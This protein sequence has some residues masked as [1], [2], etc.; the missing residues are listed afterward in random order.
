MQPTHSYNSDIVLYLLFCE[1]RNALVRRLDGAESKMIDLI[2][3]YGEK[4]AKMFEWG[5]QR[6]KEYALHILDY[7]IRT[8]STTVWTV[9]PEMKLSETLKNPLRMVKMELPFDPMTQNAIF[10]SK[11]ER[12][13]HA[14]EAKC[15]K[16]IRYWQDI[17]T[18]RLT[19]QSQNSITR[20][21]ASSL[22]KA[23]TAERSAA[24]DEDLHLFHNR[25][26]SFGSNPNPYPSAS[27]EICVE[28]LHPLFSFIP[29][30]KELDFAPEEFLMGFE[31]YFEDF[32][33]RIQNCRTE[34]IDSVPSD[35]PT[36]PELAKQDEE[37]EFMGQAQYDSSDII[38]KKMGKFRKE[39]RRPFDTGTEYAL[40]A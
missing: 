24:L 16:I 34:S 6:G 28:N 4:H 36:I 11:M 31:K 32:C 18:R 26:S 17:E 3:H 19:L 20:S 29:P 33:K 27:S 39:R 22:D 37:H 25:L 21:F 23:M 10:C 30:S 8:L 35:N 14:M 12:I 38:A 15:E 2:P 5:Y 9:R 1:C 13:E 7:Y 40:S